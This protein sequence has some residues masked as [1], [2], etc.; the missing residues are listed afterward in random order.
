[1]VRRDKREN[2][3]RKERKDAQMSSVF[4]KAVTKMSAS[5]S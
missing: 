5:S 1:M 4:S 3:G 2:E